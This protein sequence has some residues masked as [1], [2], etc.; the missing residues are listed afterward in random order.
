MHGGDHPS[1]GASKR[2]SIFMA[3]STA[4][5][6]PFVTRSPTA[7]SSLVTLPGMGAVNRPEIL[8]LA[9]RGEAAVL[10]GQR[11]TSARQW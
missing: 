11:A 2:L 8:L 4:S 9:A 1:R 3:S 6:W 10:Q 7:T 5:A